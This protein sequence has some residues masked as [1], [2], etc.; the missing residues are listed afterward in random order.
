M[1]TCI[2][3]VWSFIEGNDERFIVFYAHTMR[4]YWGGSIPRTVE[5][6]IQN[7]TR[8]TAET[9]HGKTIFYKV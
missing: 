7:A 5:K 4:E 3:W 6:Y 2:Q 8:T 1:K 9:I